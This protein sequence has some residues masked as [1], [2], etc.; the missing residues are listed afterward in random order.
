M[1]IKIYTFK[2]RRYIHSKIDILHVS[3]LNINSWRYIW[4]THFMMQGTI[5]SGMNSD[6]GL[7]TGRRACRLRYRPTR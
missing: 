5:V 3:T 1:K 6:D 2:G 7:Q 4:L